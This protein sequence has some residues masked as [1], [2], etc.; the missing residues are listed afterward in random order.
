MKYIHVPID[1][2]TVPKGHSCHCGKFWAMHPEKGLAYYVLPGTTAASLNMDERL[3]PQCNDQ[4]EVVERLMP[5]GY[6]C[7]YLD[8]VFDVHAVLAARDELEHAV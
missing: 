1:T 5:D 7:V 3:R 6:E 8:V 2:A 4:R